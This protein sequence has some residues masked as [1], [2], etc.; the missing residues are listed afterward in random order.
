MKKQW[1]AVGK[2]GK[3]TLLLLLISV[4]FFCL[5]LLLIYF[6]SSTKFPNVCIN[7]GINISTTVPSNQTT[8]NKDWLRAYRHKYGCTSSKLQ[9]AEGVPAEVAK[10]SAQACPAPFNDIY[11]FNGGEC[12]AEFQDDSPTQFL[13]FCKCALNYHGRRC[14]YLFNSEL[15]GFS[16]GHNEVVETAALS[17]LVTFLLLGFCALSCCLYLY[18][19]YGKQREAES[20]S[21][22]S[23][24]MGSSNAYS[25][26]TDTPLSAR[27]LR[28]LDYHG[29]CSL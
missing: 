2:L 23:F 3:S 19:R 29:V 28:S 5:L 12:M 8:T 7:G 20:M 22:S 6:S 10:S 17:T 14:E 15:Y 1:S 13:P 11:C 26:S 4:C 18:R 9:Q 24:V 16:V 25:S 21:C 27:Q